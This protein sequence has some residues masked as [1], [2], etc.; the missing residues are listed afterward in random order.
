M[1]ETGRR[2]AVAE[3]A[4][5]LVEIT[6]DRGRQVLFGAASSPTGAG[7]GGASSLSMTAGVMVSCGYR[8]GGRRRELARTPTGLRTVIYTR[9][10]PTASSGLLRAC[11]PAC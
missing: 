6:L 1:I 3:A 5:T 11:P 2:Q 10:I 8:R 7:V 4:E 9:D